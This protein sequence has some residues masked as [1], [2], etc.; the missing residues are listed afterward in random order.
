M[1]YSSYIGKALR[2]AVIKR[3]STSFENVIDH[4]M[5]DIISSMRILKGDNMKTIVKYDDLKRKSLNVLCVVRVLPFIF[6][7]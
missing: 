7:S 2:M 5:N 3:R 4:S 1:I 6:N